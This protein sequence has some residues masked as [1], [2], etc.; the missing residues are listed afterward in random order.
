MCGNMYYC[1]N[2]TS[3]SDDETGTLSFFIKHVENH[4]RVKQKTIK[5]NDKNHK[6]NKQ[7]DIRIHF[8]NF[9]HD[10]FP[11]LIRIFFFFSSFSAFDLHVFF[12][13]VSLRY[14]NR[15]ENNFSMLIKNGAIFLAE[16]PSL[17][18]STRTPNK[19]FES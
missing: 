5:S 16:D 9:S 8:I 14:T 2:I 19:Y 1:L 13:F 6:N 12:V 10:M 3:S 11:M 7:K 4:S 18:T 17:T 15:T